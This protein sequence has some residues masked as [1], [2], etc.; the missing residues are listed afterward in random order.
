MLW[1]ILRLTLQAH[2]D[3]HPGRLYEFDL[4]HLPLMRGFHVQHHVSNNDQHVE[5]GL[6]NESASFQ[7]RAYW[8][9][10]ELQYAVYLF[11]NVAAMQGWVQ[12]NFRNSQYIPHLP[13][14][15]P[16]ATKAV[17]IQLI[18]APLPPALYPAKFIAVNPLL[19]VLS[20][21]KHKEM[22]RGDPQFA[23]VTPSDHLFTA[24]LQA[25][26][27]ALIHQALH[28]RRTLH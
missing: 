6:G 3:V 1:R 27:A 7:M 26:Q 5:D 24:R 15:W 25:I 8:G 2:A 12:A 11:P 23:R 19:I 20:G 13:H 21:Y 22:F 14:P 10:D 9:A 16:A 28:F 17:Q 4:S 18:S